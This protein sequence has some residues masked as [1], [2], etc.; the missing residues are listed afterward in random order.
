MALRLKTIEY[1]LN[2]STG[3]VAAAGTRT[4]TTLTVYVPETTS[5]TFISAAV[6]VYFMEDTTSAVSIATVSVG[7]QV[8]AGATSTVN[9][10]GSAV[11]NSGEDQSYYFIRDGT[12]PFNTDFGSGT[13]QTVVITVTAATAQTSNCSAKLVLTYQYDDSET[14]RIKT[15]RIPLEGAT[16][17][18]TTSL[19]EIGTNQIPNL[20]DFLPEAS[21]VYRDIFFEIY[22]N[23]QVGTAST[24]D[25]TF[26]LAL[27]GEAAVADGAHSDSLVTAIMYYRVWKRTDMAT[28]STHAFKAQVSNNNLRMSCLGATLVVTY[29]YDHSSTTRVMNS[30]V[31][32]QGDSAGY[33]G[34]TT[35]GDK[36]IWRSLV[37]IQETSPISPA[38]SGALISFISSAGAT[39]RPVFSQGATSQSERTY[40]FPATVIAGGMFIH[41]RMDSG[42]GGGAGFALTRGHNNID[43]NIY[44]TGSGT[45]T[46]VSNAGA[47]TY[48][49]YRS[50]KSAD[51]GGDAN[52]N[53]PVYKHVSSLSTNVQLHEV[54]AVKLSPPESAYYMHDVLLW[55]ASMTPGTIG[56][57]GINWVA[58]RLSTDTLPG[59]WQSLSSSICETDNETGPQISLQNVSVFKKF[60][61][62]MTENTLNIASPRTYRDYW[63]TIS[64]AQWGMWVTYH[65]NVYTVSGT[66]SGYTGDG[67][68]I[69]VCLVEEDGW[70]KVQETTTA[71]GGTYSFNWYDNTQNMFTVAIVPGSRAGASLG[72]MAT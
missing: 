13:S 56:A 25:A 29:E 51:S 70:G 12:T 46:L 68:G 48:L 30:L 39:V 22:G 55:C 38:Q 65:S 23:N 62:D 20:D 52:H 41:H 27:D 21:K 33:I 6:H 40:T 1:G 17:N 69:T 45:G 50:G 64:F 71:A 72:G 2:Q 5:R 61:G 54:L 18:T 53:H 34:G 28:N 59:G 47:V 36:S 58:E 8:G 37:N 15:V 10:A 31:I 32:A 3:A 35:S 16:G 14:T 60:P 44:R 26:S 67:S 42:S 9:V 63:S 49:N 7:V 19:T 57:G 66:V 4:F 24:P 43:L 11:T